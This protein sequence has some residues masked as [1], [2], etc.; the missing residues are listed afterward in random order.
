M[1]CQYCSFNGHRMDVHNH[2]INVHPEQVRIYIDEASGKMVYEL[3][4]PVC[5]EVGKK[6]LRKPPGVLAEY[7]REIRMVA[8]DLL[9]FHL[10]DLHTPE[11]SE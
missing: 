6:V 1:N 7:E 2:L 10:Q 11:D 3:S 4:C 8:F 9:L 5:N